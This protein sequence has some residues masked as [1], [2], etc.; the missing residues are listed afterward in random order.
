[1][2]VPSYSSSS[3]LADIVVIVIVFNLIDTFSWG[4]GMK[5]KVQKIIN[6]PHANYEQREKKKRLVVSLMIK[7]SLIL[8]N[9]FNII[10]ISL[11]CFEGLLIRC[12]EGFGKSDFFN[13]TLRKR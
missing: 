13:V 10:L 6:N 2:A 8:I 7:F 3:V 12:V 1:M 5:K 11:W 4:D 9:H